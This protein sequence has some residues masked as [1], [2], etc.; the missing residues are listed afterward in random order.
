MLDPV[1]FSKSMSSI[2]KD[3]VVP[4]K[5]TIALL[6]GRIEKLEALQPL[7]GEP[8]LKGDPGKDAPAITEEDLARS[9]ARYLRECPPARGEPGLKGDPGNDGEPGRDA[10]PVSDDQL[11]R[12]V[13]QYLRAHPAAP[14][15]KGERGEPGAKGDSG[16]DADQVVLQDVID[17]LLGSDKLLS[18]VEL[19]AKEAVSAIP[20][21]KDGMPGKDG[22][23]GLKGDP[24]QQ[25]TKGDS[26]A[27]GV[28]LAGAMIDRD[29]TL[30]I[31]TTKGDAV[32]LGKV[33]GQDGKDGL[34]FD[35]MDASYN[36]ERGVTLK[37]SRGEKAKEFNFH[38]PVIMDRGYWREGLKAKQGDAVTHDGT[39]WIALRD[40]ATKPCLESKEDW[41]IGARKGRDG[42][43]GSNG[44]DAPGAVK[45]EPASA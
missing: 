10:P 38:L 18:L 43:N 36:G 15:L 20:P 9:V 34:G 42:R 45:L 24:G 25:G 26:G 37:F 8:G 27:D 41:R 12:A 35:D 4:L 31:T 6:L 14:G 22:S 19:R 16:R 23:P 2:V 40:N 29:G 11:A 5:N 17:E 3:A 28:G 7:R 39:L 33:V 1:E 44:K 32:R 13:E 21:P 30:I